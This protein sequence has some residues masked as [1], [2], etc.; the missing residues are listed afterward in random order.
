M[1]QIYMNDLC[2]RQRRARPETTVEVQDFNWPR[3]QHCRT[4]SY[5]RAI[6]TEFR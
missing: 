3:A 5:H 6:T 2:S 1:T 4:G